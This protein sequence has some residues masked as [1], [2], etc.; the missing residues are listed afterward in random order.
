MLSRAQPEREPNAGRARTCRAPWLPA[1][2][3]HNH[4]FIC[5][6]FITRAVRNW[7]FGM[8]GGKCHPQKR[9]LLLRHLR[10]KRSLIVVLLQG[11]ALSQSSFNFPSYLQGNGRQINA[12]SWPVEALGL[13]TSN[14]MNLAESFSR[15]KQSAPPQH[16]RRP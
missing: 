13:R 15:T 5:C 8:P 14:E 16:M 4:A 11:Q 7:L 9:P 6:S 1:V 3:T 12:H 10:R 2:C